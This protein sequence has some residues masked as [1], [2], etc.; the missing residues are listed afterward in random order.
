MSSNT[1]LEHAAAVSYVDLILCFTFTVY[2][3]PQ[4]IFTFLLL[5]I[6]NHTICLGLNGH[7]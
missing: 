6:V 7:H 2:I 1:I 4:L 5:F 3:H